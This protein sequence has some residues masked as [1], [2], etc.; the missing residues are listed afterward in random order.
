MG[1][2][3]TIERLSLN[4]ITTEHWSLPEA[5]EGC[6]RAKIPWIS[7]WRHKIAE[8]GLAESKKLVR[9]AGLRVSSVCRGGMFP[10]ASMSERQKRLDDNRRAVEEAAELGAEVLVLVCGPAPDK[11]ISSARKWVAEGI[12]QLVPYAKA[13][14]VRLGIE[15]LHPMYAAERSVIV[16]LAHANDLAEQYSPSDVGVIVDVFHVWW[17]PD[18]DNQIA[19]ASGR[20]FGFHVSD[21]IVPTP[22]L[23]MARGMMGDGVIEIHRIRQAVEASGYTGPIEVEI[24]N[25]AIWEMP[26]DDVLAQMKERYLEHV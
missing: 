1:K 19:R 23:L 13:C 11:D 24:F 18:L 2:L 22:D 7:L 5:V 15:P 3:Q 14:G 16:T 9:E 20:I 10:A 4:Q 17:D 26:G 12:E 6:V 8:T 25:R 21:W